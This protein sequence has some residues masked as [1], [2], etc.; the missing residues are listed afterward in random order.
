[1]LVPRSHGSVMPNRRLI[2]SEI[3]I[4]RNRFATRLC[5]SLGTLGVAV[6]GRVFLAPQADARVLAHE[7]A[8]V[9]QQ[10]LW[11]GLPVPPAWTEAEANAV[12]LGVIA[13]PRLP[14]NP[15]IPSCWEEVGHYYTV[16]YVLLC[17]GVRDPLA[18][19]IAFYAQ[20]PDEISDLDAAQ[21]GFAMLRQSGEMAEAVWHDNTMGHLE[22]AAIWLNNGFASMVPYG[23]G[24]MMA[25]ERPR[26]YGDFVRYITVQRGLHALTG[27]NVEVETANRTRILRR[28]D[29]VAAPLDYGIALHAFG[30]SY[31]HREADGVHMY[32]TGS[33]HAIDTQVARSS[34]GHIPEM[35]IHPDAVGP[36][37]RDIFLRY[38]G[39]MYQLFSQ[40]FPPGSRVTAFNAANMRRNLDSIVSSSNAAA[41][42]PGEHTRQ[43]R[44]IRQFAAEIVPG[45]MHV[46][47]PENQDDVPID[48][49]N[50]RNTDIRVTRPEVQH[51]LT[52]AAQWS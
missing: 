23:S 12:S 11:R 20:M 28:I 52:R 29:P 30:D 10:R 33:G 45:G 32:P 25:R 47:D 41:D 43:I 21:A 8:H 48:N 17:V 42:S 31:A 37:H 50:P 24:Y 18:R 5:E 19:R 6:E 40:T 35:T 26:V 39:D 16:Y 3:R 49:F 14:L 2:S 36:H 7:L 1:M 13:R 27:S 51:A 34:R 15:A 46:Y 22:D 44:M 9:A 38:A 4:E